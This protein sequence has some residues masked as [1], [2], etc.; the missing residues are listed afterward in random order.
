MLKDCQLTCP[1]EIINAAGTNSVSVAA[2]V[3]ASALFFLVL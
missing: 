3:L 1:T 2:A